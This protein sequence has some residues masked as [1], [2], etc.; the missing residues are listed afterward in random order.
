MQQRGDDQLY[1]YDRSGSVISREQGMRYDAGYAVRM[2]CRTRDHERRAC[3]SP[4]TTYTR[5]CIGRVY[6]P[7]AVDRRARYMCAP[8]RVPLLN[9]TRND[10]SVLT[11]SREACTYTV[12]R[13]SVASTSIVLVVQ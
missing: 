3:R 6:R 13:C 12:C 7:Q 2:L 11:L 10:T 8:A 5:A 9:V 1:M 4:A